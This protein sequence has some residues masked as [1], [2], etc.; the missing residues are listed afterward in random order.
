MPCP[1]PFHFSQSVDYIY[2]FCPLPDPPPGPLLPLNNVHT[3][4]HALPK[5]EPEH[6]RI[7]TFSILV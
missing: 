2:V 7:S 5:T 1:G 3:S 6:T 4:V